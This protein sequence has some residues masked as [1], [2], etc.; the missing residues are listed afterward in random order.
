VEVLAR[1]LAQGVR[2]LVR[3]E[4]TRLRVS[5]DPPELGRIAVDLAKHDHTVSAQFRVESPQTQLLLENSLHDL[6]TILGEQGVQLGE[7][8]VA[9]EQQPGEQGRHGWDKAEEP[10]PPSRS[11]EHQPATG[12]REQQGELRRPRMFGYNTMEMTA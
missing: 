4:E 1:E 12:R 5:I 9:V 7:L 8:S 6:R 10:L 3:G 2:L 11:A